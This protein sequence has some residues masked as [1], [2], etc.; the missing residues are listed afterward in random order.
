MKFLFLLLLFV[1]FS[2]LHLILASS[3]K[4]LYIYTHSLIYIDLLTGCT[5][6]EPGDQKKGDAPAKLPHEED[7]EQQSSTSTAAEELQLLDEILSRAQKLRAV[8]PSEVRS[9]FQVTLPSLWI[10]V[11]SF[12]KVEG[13]LFVTCSTNL[14]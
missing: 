11:G 7:E 9:F 10:M 3:M 5:K 6:N 13:H 1:V 12:W 2:P 14:V 4:L 8:Q